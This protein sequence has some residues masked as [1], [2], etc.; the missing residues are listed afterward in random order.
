MMYINHDER[1]D[2]IKEQAVVYI[3]RNLR[4]LRKEYVR[5]QFN[6]TIHSG[7]HCK[8]LLRILTEEPII[9][10]PEEIAKELLKNL[11]RKQDILREEE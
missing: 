3:K 8:E 10:Q 9:Q 1:I 5:S 6:I 2:A 7:K 4:E 11:D